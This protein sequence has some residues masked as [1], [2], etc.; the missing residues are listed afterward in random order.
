MTAPPA[1]PATRAL[2]VAAA[3][4]ALLYAAL[5]AAVSVAR[6]HQLR[7]GFDLRNFDQAV[8]LLLHGEGLQERLSRLAGHFDPIGYVVAPLYA[9]VGPSPVW[10]LLLQS[11]MGG[12][13]VYAV[14]LLG[15]A[16]GLEPPLALALTWVYAL[17]GVPHNP[18]L[19][20]YHG[21]ALAMPLLLLA[22]AAYEARRRAAFALCAALALLC[23]EDVALVLAAWGLY[24]ALLRRDPRT[25]LAT[26]AAGLAVFGLVTY[27]VIPFF[28][29]GQASF[30]L[31][32]YTT[33]GDTPA[34]VIAGV[35]ARPRDVLATAAA[36]GS[37][38]YLAAVL[39]PLFG[40]PLLAPGALLPAAVPLAVNWLSSWPGQHTIR[41]H[42]LSTLV[43]VA[44]LAAVLGAERLA[45][46]L[47][48]RR[49]AAARALP[50]ALAAGAALLA[51]V[52][53]GG[54]QLWRQRPAHVLRSP[55]AADLAR[56]RAPIPPGARL[57][58]SSRLSP[59][60]SY[61]R[62]ALA[63]P[64]DEPDLGTADFVLSFAGD[65]HDPALRRA[66]ARSGRFDE[67]ARAGPF[68]LYA[69][70]PR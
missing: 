42:Y 25:G 24:V 69:A 64:N 16:R 8:W 60:F 31:G 22:F 59:W 37:A 57:V 7:T 1:S 52:H 48:S 54:S 14:W 33:F 15:R 29:A 58:T 32:R 30:F 23:K 68:V 43:P 11:A 34:G 28:H 65:P 51:L 47:A 66:V 26:A 9:L 2:H 21:V 35:L 55:H 12:V 53:G 41:Y 40:L 62:D 45:R 27:V 70:R 46:R 10:L 49:P 56:V 67:A 20:D 61:R 6:H 50:L 18:L 3:A 4:L 17:W 39:V 19:F 5:F 44:M 38:S 36:H 13:A 63:F